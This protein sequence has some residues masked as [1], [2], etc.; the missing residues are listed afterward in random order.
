MASTEIEAFI[1][2]VIEELL[3]MSHRCDIF[4]F[5]Q[6]SFYPL[7]SEKNLSQKTPC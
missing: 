7:N 6:H 2:D 3:Q 4:I 1:E 5:Y